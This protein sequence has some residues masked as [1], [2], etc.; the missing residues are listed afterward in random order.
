MGLYCVLK[1]YYNFLAIALTVLGIF[2]LFVN[3][4]TASETINSY[5]VY[6]KQ[7][8]GFINKVNNLKNGY[9][10]VLEIP[11]INLKQGFFEYNSSLNDVDKNIEVI[12]TSKMPDVKGSNLILAAHSGNS[13]IAYFKHLDLLNIKDEVYIYY[14]NKKYKYVI[15]DIYD[16]TKTGYIDI[17]RDKSKTT[18]TLITCKKNTNMQTVYIGYLEN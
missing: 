14:N 17:V 13:N 6:N 8:K 15:N 11:K 3:T 1:K 9:L 16:R 2:I 18:I 4:A 5:T 10:A 12:E 7:Y